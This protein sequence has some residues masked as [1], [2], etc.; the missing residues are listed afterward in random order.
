MRPRV[1]ENAVRLQDGDRGPRGGLAVGHVGG[2]LL[3]P[4]TTRRRRRPGVSRTTPPSRD[5]GLFAGLAWPRGSVPVAFTPGTTPRCPARHWSSVHT[6]VCGPSLESSGGGR[7]GRWLWLLS[8]GLV[9]RW[10]CWPSA[11]SVRAAASIALWAAAIAEW[12]PVLRNLQGVLLLL[13]HPSAEPGFGGTEP[14]TQRPTRHHWRV[15]AHA[16]VIIRPVC[17]GAG[18]HRAP[19][20]I[21]SSASMSMSPIQCPFLWSVKRVRVLADRPCICP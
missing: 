21:S 13:V 14:R 3:R 15:H 16:P 12:A 19:G 10:R 18:S 7:G 9:E 2:G 5:A 20:S 4:A 17:A 6:V 8:S 11:A 1:V